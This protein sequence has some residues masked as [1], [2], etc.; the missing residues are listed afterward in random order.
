MK[1][2]HN[3]SGIVIEGNQVGKQFIGKIILLPEPKKYPFL[4]LNMKQK[5]NISTIGITYSILQ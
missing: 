5:T 3:L 1:I 2:K 4:K